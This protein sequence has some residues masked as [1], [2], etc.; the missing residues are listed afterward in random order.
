MRIRPTSESIWRVSYPLM[1]AGVSETI[2]DVTDAI[3]LG[4]Y[5]VVELGAV[6]LADA[7]YGLLLVAVIG[8]GDGIQVMLARRA[9]QGNARAVGAV[10]NQGIYLLV[11]ASVA[12]FA[13]VRFASPWLTAAFCS[14]PEVESAVNDYLSIAAY[15]VPFDALNIALAVFYLAVSR[16]RAI[17]GAT[18]LLVVVN[19]ALDWGL[20][21]GNLGAPRLGIE[22]AAIASVAAEASAFVFLVAYAWWRGDMRRYGL[23]ALRG[24]NRPLARL[25]NRVSMPIAGEALVETTRWFIFFALIEQLGE[26]ALAGAN[27]VYSYY[28]ILLIPAEA[29][30]ET[31]CSMVSNLIGQDKT[32][33][34]ALLLRRSIRLG[35]LLTVPL[36]LLVAL[37]PGPLLRAFSTEEVVIAEAVPSLLV[38]VATVAVAIPGEVLLAAIVGTG[39]TR[40]VLRIEIVMATTVLAMA[41]A[42][43][44]LLDLGVTWIWAALLTG[45]LVRILMC[46]TRLRSRSWAHLAF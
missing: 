2:V 21:F 14:S 13:L 10:F 27:I 35:F 4:H 7:I 1:I 42:A 37:L 29:F 44:L 43:V 34:V 38:V 9:G 3:F 25:L 22:G 20:V 11:L 19:I 28:A 30:G 17:I 41:A 33:R 31:A 16:T 15:G 8:L 12:V 6:G 40:T 18:A 32:S 46:A 45:W 5:G 39:D 36:L 23:F 24:W 26:Q